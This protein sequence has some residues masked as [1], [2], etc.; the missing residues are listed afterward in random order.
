M[1]R[2][3][4]CHSSLPYVVCASGGIL[5]ITGIA[6]FI[7]TR[8]S[9][10][11]L[12][13][14]A[15]VSSGI[16]F[17]A[18]IAPL[19]LTRKTASDHQSE[20]VEGEINNRSDHRW[21]TLRPAI[22]EAERRVTRRRITIAP[23]VIEVLG[24]NQENPA[25]QIAGL[26]F[27]VSGDAHLPSDTAIIAPWIFAELK[28]A[29]GV[30]SSDVISTFVYKVDEL[31]SVP[32]IH[33]TISLANPRAD[34]YILLPMDHICNAIKA[35]FH[36]GHVQFPRTFIFSGFGTN[37][38]CHLTVS[39]RDAA[40]AILQD[41]GECDFDLQGI[42]DSNDRIVEMKEA[43]I[44]LG[45]IS[46]APRSED[47]DLMREYFAALETAQDIHTFGVYVNTNAVLRVGQ[48]MGDRRNL[49]VR[50]IQGRS[51]ASFTYAFNTGGARPR[52]RIQGL[53]EEESDGDSVS[54]SSL[55]PLPIQ[56]S[57][58]DRLR[59]NKL[60]GVTPEIL[61]SCG[62]IY[63]VLHGADLPLGFVNALLLCGPPGNGKTALTA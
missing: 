2:I 54:S 33:A 29:L 30:P 17:L 10:H 16:G 35:I 43:I 44:V 60:F 46:E 23:S 26:I 34:Q 36:K 49:Y 9:R 24:L 51:G 8:L 42:I 52:I 41:G 4:S 14:P 11:N 13:L 48:V 1:D 45:S 38:R 18:V 7:L 63:D 25:V 27:Q 31:V 21:I 5:L 57:F 55:S 53:E 40:V 32:R 12:L 20:R 37:V 6:L 59:R 19:L 56:M 22:I 47:L 15:G 39:G 3:S 62:A 28:D 58:H 50:E 61:A